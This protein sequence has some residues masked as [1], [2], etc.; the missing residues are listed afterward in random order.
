MAS[1]AAA[2]IFDLEDSVL[3]KDKAGAREELAEFL[4]ANAP[5]PK[6]VWVRVNNERGDG[7][8]TLADLA[9]LD[10]T[11]IDGLVLPK[12]ELDVLKIVTA[13]VTTLAERP[14]PIIGLLET[15]RGILEAVDIARHPGVLTLGIGRADLFAELRLNLAAPLESVFEQLALHLVLAC[16]AAGI[17]APIAPV[18]L[19]L[20]IENSGASRR[21]F[22]LGFRSQT[23]LHP[24]QCA[25][26]NETFIPS[27]EEYE[28]AR[29]LLQ[30]FADSNGIWVSEDGR[31]IDRAVARQ[32]EEICQRYVASRGVDSSSVSIDSISAERKTS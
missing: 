13:Q 16:A 23:A 17:A 4:R 19:D 28:R 8:D 7:N 10:L 26:I 32:S 5:L 29:A 24:A 18:E 2:V 1:E 3:A 21:Y 12:I 14:I 25:G 20:T 22:D 6:P 27:E 30:V 31:F 15:A 11:T 9:A